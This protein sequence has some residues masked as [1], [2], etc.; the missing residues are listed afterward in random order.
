V[1]TPFVLGVAS[2]LHLASGGLFDR[3]AGKYVSLHDCLYPP[4]YVAEARAAKAAKKSADEA[5]AAAREAE[6]K[7]MAEAAA[8]AEAEEMKS[9]PD[10]ERKAAEAKAA[11]AAKE[12]KA[13]A[14]KKKSKEELAAEKAE[15]EAA[16]AAEAEAARAEAE[17]EEALRQK[18]AEQPN[19][20]DNLELRCLPNEWTPLFYAARH[21]SDTNVRLLLSLGAD[22]IARDKR[23][24]T[25]LHKAAIA[26][27]AEGTAKIKT[28]LEA[29]AEIDAS[30][31]YGMTP[32]HAAAA[33]E[34][35]ESVL[36][37]SQL[38]ASQLVRDG[39][40]LDGNTP[41]QVAQA[42]G[43]TQIVDAL[44]MY[45]IRR[46]QLKGGATKYVPA[47]TLFWEPPPFS[48][49]RMNPQGKWGPKAVVL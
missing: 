7:A 36:C 21:G 25:P 9:L 31:R 29:G 23:G 14:S 48:H 32:L 22:A 43:F 34:Q 45:Q 4:D 3:S 10:K 8:Q 16:I 39:P 47:D 41:F 18:A 37:L 44:K 2:P 38:G 20:L 26:G 19:W 27:G 13:K 11:K 40:L 33:T 6:E 46:W 28:L 5:A 17:E 1:P 42:A 24:A 49:K 30:D 15:V 12:T 35:L